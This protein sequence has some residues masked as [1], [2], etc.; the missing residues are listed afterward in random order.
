MKGRGIA[1]NEFTAYFHR[2]KFKTGG[3]DRE[4]EIG[5]SYELGVPTAKYIRQIKI[6][7]IQNKII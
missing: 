3:W 6:I 5:F 1:G 7:I 4:A 2:I